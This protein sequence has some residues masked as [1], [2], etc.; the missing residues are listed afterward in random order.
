MSEEET[1]KKP[2]FLVTFQGHL[3]NESITKKPL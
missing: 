2:K 1:V 3:A